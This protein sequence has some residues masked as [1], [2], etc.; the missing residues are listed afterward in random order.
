MTRLNEV[1][2]DEEATSFVQNEVVEQK[3]PY[4][5]FV[6]A[7]QF[8]HQ[9]A[10]EFLGSLGYSDELIDA[11]TAELFDGDPNGSLYEHQAETIDAIEGDTNDN[12]LAVPTAT[13]KT[14]AF[15]LPVLEHCLSTDEPGLKSLVVY[16]MKTL[17]V[18]QLNRFISY[19]DQINRYRDPEDRITI[20]IWDSDTPTRVGTRDYEIEEGSYIR[21]LE[22]PR[23][24]GEKLRILGDTTVGTEDNQYSWIRVTRDAIR[25]GADILL[26]N[27]EALDHMFVSDNPETRQIL[28][29]SPGENPVEHIVFDEAHV[30]SGISGASIRLLSERLTDFYESRD[31]QITMVSATVDNPAE[32][33]HSLTGTPEDEINSLGFTS[34]EFPVTGTPN[35]D[36]FT[37][38]SAA[39]LAG[40]LALARLERVSVEEFEEYGLGDALQTAE[41]VGLVAGSDGG[42]V[43]LTQD[44]AWIRDTLAD[45]VES[46][47]ETDDYDDHEDVA[48]AP[49][50][51]DRLSEA[52]LDAGG[53][54]SEWFEYVVDAVP[55]AAEFAH[56]FDE[57][58]TGEVGFKHYDDL[59]SRLD[60]EG[61]DDTEGILR[62]VMMFGRLAGMVT[63]KYHVFLKPPH[64]AY[65]CQSCQTVTR[66]KHCADCGGK[67]S[68]LQFCK[69]CHYPYVEVKSAD[70][71]SADETAFRPYDH[72]GPVEK[73]PDCGKWP[74]LTDVGVPTSSLLSY[75][76]TEV[77]R[78]SPSKKTLVF[79]DSHSAAESVGD[80]II[81]TEYGLMAET[82][83]VQELIE[84][85]GTA[86]NYDV[87]RDVSDRLRAEY[88]EPLIQNEIDEDGTAYNFLRTLL[89]DIEGHAMLHNVEN[90]LDSALV[91]AEA[92]TEINDPTELVIAHETYKLFVK[93][94]GVGFKKNKIGIEGLSIP[95]IVD[96]VASRSGFDHETVREVLPGVLERLIAESIVVEQ[97]WEEVRQTV[98]N[99]RVGDEKKEDTFDY[100][101]DARAEFENAGLGD[102]ESGILTRVPRRDSSTL[103]LLERAAFC[104]SCYRSFPVTEAGGLRD[105]PG[106][107]SPLEIYRRFTQDDDGDL[108][109]AP[110][111]ADVDSG[112]PFAVDHWAH[113]VTDPIRDGAEPEFITV[114]IHKGNIPHT[115]RGAI[116][117]GF[118]KDDPD[119]NIVSA[120]PTMELGVD[121]GTLETVA[122]VGIPPTL[123][124]YVQR[125]G[126]TGRTR[127]SSSLVM[128]AVRGEHPVDGHYYANLDTFLDDF[129]PVRV[130]NPYEFE[131]LLAGHVVTETF[132]YLARN[133]HPSN[134]FERMYQLNEVNQSLDAFV[135]DVENNLDI[136]GEFLLSERREALEDHLES[137][138]GD[139][140]V[141]TFAHVFE[142]DGPLSLS[143]R[144]EKTFS[145]ITSMSGSAETNKAFTENNNRLDRWLSR[146]GYL[147]NYRSFGQQFPV[148][149][150]GYSEGIEFEGA[151][152][153]YDMY[154]G[155][156]NEL[157]AVITLHGTDYI[158]DDVHGSSTPL[159]TLHVCDNEECDRP[160]EGYDRSVEHC[161]YCGDDLIETNVHGVSSVEC[162]PARGG[163]KMY[164]THGLMTTSITSD[165]SQ[166]VR[167]S[168]TRDVFGLSCEATYGELDV[169]D[170]V[171]AFERRHSASPDKEVLRSEAVIEGDSS[172]STAGQSWEERLEEADTEEYAPVGQQYHTQGIT[173]R[174]DADDIQERVESVESETAS[175]PQAL[176]SLEQSLDKAIAVVAQCDRS[177]FRVQADRT[178]GEVVVYVIDS[179]QGGNGI[180]WQVWEELADV[181]R[182]VAEVADCERCNDYCDECLL[183]SRTP[184]YYLENDLLNN[185]TL[186][187]VTGS[188]GN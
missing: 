80:S 23:E 17:G 141:E 172:A 177:D 89:D 77:C 105:C 137:V 122:Q 58:T 86:D 68:E 10:A 181:E 119:V 104:S 174:F 33:A 131:E 64:R 30:W 149:F 15:F 24:D 29:E 154:P 9:P 186:A 150:E 84:R 118:R 13:G 127:G 55:E 36:R 75:M 121:I 51:R 39:E 56:W 114:G 67:N 123:T 140:G 34:R 53:L 103:A 112:W 38:C 158:V 91:T 95:K 107:G 40:V 70:G 27:P 20:G 50:A 101:E 185:R 188:G 90:L 43:V 7:P 47:L 96:R 145:R 129:E 170:F 52:L 153:L 92:L 14:E 25:N 82:L 117:E 175:W 94:P 151:G 111:Y 3:G 78:T 81:S 6:D 41:E 142:G 99:A 133:P 79:S 164:N 115:L 60:D 26:T 144:V 165:G 83:Y 45:E 126:R 136:L 167:T 130:P 61:V 182:R 159:A 35:F 93:D 72:A 125:S 171:Y 138:F 2:S 1:V 48:A 124:N 113:D 178:G 116:E 157:G 134:V 163:Q 16:P 62:T 37:P 49:E 85:G 162:K 120:T 184:A 59:L 18:D 108:V 179:R 176:V 143:S 69:R 109:A 4:V 168:T 32:L 110:G 87:F 42:G 183:L 44:A 12:I 5:E 169:T 65:L 132:A 73:C 63:E 146:L 22:C 88:W 46:L 148:K 57:D 139:A 100:L 180:S 152:R 11:V 166:S 31:P 98:A 173:L 8:H 28:G 54:Y 155:E 147:A 71:E 21:G 161:P 97:S 156:E 160:F 128:T 76:L 135:A 19:L 106:C 102:S 66:D 187:A 74:K